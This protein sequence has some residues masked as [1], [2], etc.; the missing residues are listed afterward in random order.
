MTNPSLTHSHTHTLQ[1]THRKEIMEGDKDN[2]NF[3]INKIEE[4][5]LRNW[6]TSEPS[7]Y[8]IVSLQF[9]M[10]HVANFSSEHWK[11]SLRTHSSHN[12]YVIIVRWRESEAHIKLLIDPKLS[13][14]HMALS[15]AFGR[16][17]RRRKRW[18]DEY[19]CNTFSVLL[20]KN[21]LR[22]NSQ[23]R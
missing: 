17:M 14:K 12:F 15:D 8:I 23:Y 3:T 19:I 20:E 22:R 16:S 2:N 7:F 13:I 6:C 21:K 11:K 10:F 5:E 9:I 1:G 18:F 4:V